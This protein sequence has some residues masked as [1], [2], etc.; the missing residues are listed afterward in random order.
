MR[1]ESTTDRLHS[2]TT[3]DSTGNIIYQAVYTYP[4]PG[5]PHYAQRSRMEVTQKSPDGTTTQYY[6]VYT[7]DDFDQLKTA[8]TYSGAYVAGA[9]PTPASAES[10]N[11]DA[12]GNQTTADGYS[13]NDLNQY[14]MIPGQVATLTYDANGNLRFDGTFNY[15]WDAA[16]RLSSVDAVD[17][18]VKLAF[19]YDSQGRRI[20]KKA[21]AWDIVTAAWKT[22]PDADTTFAYSGT[23]LLAEF[24]ALRGNKLLRAYTWGPSL[25]GSIGGLLAITDYT[26]ATTATYSPFY[27]GNGNLMG[28]QDATGA[29]V[30]TYSYS[31]FGQLLART[32][33]GP[34]G[35]TDP[36][37]F[38][39]QTM[40]RDAETGLSV[41]PMRYY[42]P[43]LERWL[44]RDPSGEASGPLYP[45]CSNDPV[46]SVDPTGLDPINL[47]AMDTET[48]STFLRTISLN[49]LQ[50]AGFPP[51]QGWF[52]SDV[53]YQSRSDEWIRQR[54]ALVQ[55]YLDTTPT[56]SLPLGNSWMTSIRQTAI[57]RGQTSDSVAAET[58]VSPLLVP[59][60]EKQRQR[61]ESL[62]A[63]IAHELAEPK[64]DCSDGAKELMSVT[65]TKGL[66]EAYLKFEA[67][68]TNCAIGQGIAGAVAFTFTWAGAAK[69]LGRLASTEALAAEGA[70][71]LRAAPRTISPAALEEMGATVRLDPA[72]MAA[73]SV[74]V[75]RATSLNIVGTS[76]SELYGSIPRTGEFS[77]IDWTGYP[78]GLPRPSGPFRILPA[79]E[80]AEALAAKNA[81]NGAI[82]RQLPLW[83]SAELD[84]HEIQPVKFGG[85]PTDLSNKIPILRNLHQQQVTPWWNALQ[86][87]IEGGP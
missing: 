15:H 57:P 31:A 14:T 80:Y 24:D 28:L 37:P 1:Y 87:R 68:D 60:L 67:G 6:V 45:Y 44:N 16:N 85:S 77:I 48:L 11:F 75:P 43:T 20:E 52:E 42:S 41:F 34:A 36:N 55:T 61:Q 18:S 22:T 49:T 9:T 10:F 33:N 81:A 62:A 66:H 29:V 40:Y 70:S 86:G 23:N 30:A 46:N 69:G 2:T 21:F 74:S 12:V 84:W 38:G 5:Q 17:H 59:F 4:E 56:G 8:T 58:Y 19:A 83:S 26:G 25:G 54:N 39:Y 27:D 13:S 51:S 50:Q 64:C 53:S 7:Y 76:G 47:S 65:A 82:R 63:N 35:T 78:A 79:S 3:T 73:E 32:W 71:A 72:A